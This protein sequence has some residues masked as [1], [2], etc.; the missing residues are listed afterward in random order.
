MYQLLL[1]R[2]LAYLCDLLGT[3]EEGLSLTHNTNTA[4]I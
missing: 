3:L 4:I 2:I 1:T